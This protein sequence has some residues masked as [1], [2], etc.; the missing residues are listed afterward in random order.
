MSE[1]DLIG[2]FAGPNAS[3]YANT[4]GVI[5]STSKTTWTFNPAAMLFGAV[6]AGAR[7]LSF[8]FLIWLSWTSPRL[9]RLFRAST[10]V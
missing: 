4:F 6:W 5:Q 10:V 3:Y 8:L 1:E 7:G 2:D 9:V